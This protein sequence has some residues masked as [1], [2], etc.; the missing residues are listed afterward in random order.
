[1]HLV[2]MHVSTSCRSLALNPDLW[3]LAA[4]QAKH[5]AA[6]DLR[7]WGRLHIQCMYRTKW[8]WKG[9]GVGEEELTENYIIVVVAYEMGHGIILIAVAKSQ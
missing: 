9:V 4:T 3:S 1:M 2:D 7:H 8:R 6:S 5:T